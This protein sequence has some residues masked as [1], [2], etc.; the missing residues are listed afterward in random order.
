MKKSILLLAAI[1]ILQACTSNGVKVDIYNP[2]DWV[3]VNEMVELDYSDITKALAPA[4]G[5]SI[6]VLDNKGNQVAYQTTFDNKLIFNAD[7]EPNAHAQYRIEI[8]IPDT[9]ECKV[10]GH[11]FPERL[12][13]FA[14]ENDCIAFRAYGPALQESGEKAFGYDVWVKNVNYPV[15]YDRYMTELNPETKALIQKLM[16]TNPDSAAALSKSVSYHYDHGNGLDYYKVGPTLGAGTAAL[17]DDEGKIIHPYCFE[18]YEILDNGPLRMTVSLKYR[19]FIFRN[20]TITETRVI[21][22]DAGSQ[23]NKID[24]TYHNLSKPATMVSGIALHDTLNIMEYD[25]TLGYAAYADPVDIE[26]GQTYLGM[27]YPGAVQNASSVY[28]DSAEREERGAEGYLLLE[29]VY[30]PGETVTY[31]AGAGWSKWG[32]EQPDDWFA[33]MQYYAATLHTPLEITLK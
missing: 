29:R 24:V 17:V 14:W 15:V 31:Y 13:D 16:Q 11:F 10:Q 7:I 2:S 33:Y 8:G 6:I 28:F 5:E 27:A 21:T 25:A 3:R 22:L 1:A 4:E 20:D 9:F 12:D 26:N 18:S 23:L 30:E 32:F 19:P